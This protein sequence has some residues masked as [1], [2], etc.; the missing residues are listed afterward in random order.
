M[1]SIFPLGSSTTSPTMDESILLSFLSMAINLSASSE[2]KEIKSPPEVCG[3]KRRSIRR[4][5]TLEWTLIRQEK[6]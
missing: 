4:G 5:G 2:G 1:I 6:N 3:S